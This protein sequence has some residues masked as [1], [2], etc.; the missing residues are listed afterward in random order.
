MFK[1]PLD[2]IEIATLGFGILAGLALIF[3][4]FSAL[5]SFAI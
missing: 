4:D 3:F 2:P 5:L 1:P